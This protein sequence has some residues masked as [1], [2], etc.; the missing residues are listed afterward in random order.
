MPNE[1]FYSSDSLVR[2]GGAASGCGF[3]LPVPSR[4]E[5]GFTIESSLSRLV[6]DLQRSAQNTAAVITASQRAA[7][8]IGATIAEMQAHGQ[9]TAAAIIEMLRPAPLTSSQINRYLSSLTTSVR[10]FPITRIEQRNNN[11]HL[12]RL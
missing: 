12:V 3:I 2:P 7:E 11:L 6:A 9:R 4:V 8:E 5:F 1:G 10:R